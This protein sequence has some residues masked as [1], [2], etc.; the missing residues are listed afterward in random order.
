MGHQIVTGHR[1]QR[2]PPTIFSALPN[3]K[4]NDKN[5][6]KTIRPRPV[7]GLQRGLS[8]PFV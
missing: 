5:G 4:N 6:E 7:L 8:L 3:A 2:T 1:R